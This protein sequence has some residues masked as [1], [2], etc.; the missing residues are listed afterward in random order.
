MQLI[1]KGKTK[2]VYKL[3]D[4]NILLQFK[5]DATVDEA[6]NIDTGGNKVGA[7][8]EGIGLASLKT[9]TYFF[10]KM[11]DAGIPSHFIASDFEAGTMTVKAASFFGNGLEFI[12]RLKATG[13]F[14]RRY[15]DYATEGQDLNY[16]VEVSIK[17]DEAG[18]PMITE[19]ALVELGLLTSDQYDQLRSWTK[20][21]TKIVKEDLA[22][23]GLT[24]YDMKVEFGLVDGELTLIDEI[25]P[26]SMRVYQGDKHLDSLEL[27][28]YFA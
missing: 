25:S 5:D 1:K 12:C 8:I 22:A 27:G 2:D 13:S 26:G 10:E 7:K 28:G 14:M 20:A 24:L 17:D 21:I 16:L 23:K 19:D 11:Q 9:T 18:D 6:G 3:E 4:G 15:G